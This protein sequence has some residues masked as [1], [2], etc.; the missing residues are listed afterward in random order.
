M[1]APRRH[2]LGRGRRRTSAGGLQRRRRALL[3]LLV[4]ATAAGLLLLAGRGAAAG[5]LP[6]FSAPAPPPLRVPAL[7]AEAAKLFAPAPAPA[8][9]EHQA[10]VE[11]EEPELCEQDGRVYEITC[12]G[13]KVPADQANPYALP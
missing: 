10:A 7:P 5:R 6:A 4:E 2:L 13:V 11:P 9:G 3:L 8:V 1:A 12:D